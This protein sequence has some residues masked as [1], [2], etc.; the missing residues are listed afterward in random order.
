MTPVDLSFIGL[1]DLSPPP[2][3]THS[4]SCEEERKRGREEERKRGREEER[5]KSVRKPK[6][7]IIFLN[8]HK[9]R[10]KEV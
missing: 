4:F 6:K 8:T 9:T 3:Y 5:K 2:K 7:W 1:C 10:E